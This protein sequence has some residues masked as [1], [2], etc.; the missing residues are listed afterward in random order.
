MKQW[1]ILNDLVVD[2]FFKTFLLLISQ[3]LQPT[4]DIVLEPI[5]IMLLLL[6]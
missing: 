6:Y 5:F 2:V 4:G 3:N 1:L